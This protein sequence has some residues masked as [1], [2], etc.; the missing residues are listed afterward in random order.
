MGGG[1]SGASGT[2]YQQSQVQI[3][4]EVM[5]RYNAVNSRAEAAAATPW[6]PYGGQFVAPVNPTQQGGINTITGAAGIDTPY[7]QQATNVLNQSLGPTGQLYGTAAQQVGQGYGAGT[8]YTQQGINTAGGATSAAMPFNGLAAGQLNSAYGNTQPLNNAAIGL[9]AGATGQVNPG[10]LNIGQYMSPYNEGVVQST[11][12][13]LRQDQAMGRADLRDQ[14]IMGGSFGGDRSGVADANLQRQQNL[15]YGQTAAQLYNANYGQALGAAQ[16]QQGVGLSAAQANRAALASGAQ[17]IAGIGQQQFGQGAAAAQGNLGIGQQ[18]YGQGQGLAATQMQGGNQLFQQGTG[19]AGAN[20]GIAQ[21]IY[22]TAAGTANSYGQLGTQQL[23]NQLTQGQAQVGAGTVQQQTQQA[24]DTAKYQQFMQEKGYPFQ[25]AQFLANI[26]MG[27]GAQSGSTTNTVTGSPQP[28][29]SDERLKENVHVIGKTNDGQPIIR[30]NY[31]GDPSTQIGLSA[32]ETEKHHPDAVGLSSGFKTVDYDAAT[33]N[34]I[35]KAGGGGLSTDMAGILAQQ[36]AMYPG[37]HDPRGVASGVGPHGIAIAPLKAQAPER[38]KVDMSRAQQQQQQ[39]SGAKQTVDSALGMYGTGK[40]LASAYNEGKETFVGKAGTKAA[41]GTMTNGTQ[42]WLGTGGQLRPGEGSAAGLFTSKGAGLDSGT[43]KTEANPPPVEPPPVEPPPVEPPVVVGDAGS[44]GATATADAGMGAGMGADMFGSGLSFFAN[45]GGR[46]ERAAGGGA[47]P[48]SAADGYI[49]DELLKP[50]APDK[51]DEA[52]KIA[53]GQPGGQQ[54]GKKDGTGKAI[55]SLVGGIA[56]SYFGPIGSMAGST[57]GGML[58]GMVARGGRVGLATGGFETNDD[59]GDGADLAR[60]REERTRGQPVPSLGRMPTARVPSAGSGQTALAAGAHD[61]PADDIYSTG[62]GI[63]PEAVRNGPPPNTREEVLGPQPVPVIVR[64][65]SNPEAAAIASR[66]QTGLGIRPEAVR[67]GP[68]VVSEPPATG[69]GIRPEAVRE[70]PPAPRRTVQD[71]VAA[72]Q[73]PPPAS[74]PDLQPGGTGLAAGEIGDDN[75]LRRPTQ[76]AAA[77][78]KSGY[79]PPDPPP[80]AQNPPADTDAAIYDRVM[81]DGAGPPLA[82][83]AAVPAA[84]PAAGT[85]V[86]SGAPAGSGNPGGQPGPDERAPGFDGA[87]ARTFR[88]EG[89]YN[90]R[91]ANGVPVNFGINQAYHPGVDVSKLTKDQAR[92]IYKRQYWDAIEADKLDPRLQH[93]AFDTAVI[94]GPAKAKE[95]LAASGGDPAKFMQLREQFEEGLV[96]S[97]PAKYGKYQQSWAN[98]RADLRGGNGQALAFRPEGQV[99]DTGPPAGP[100]AEKKEPDFIERAGNWIDKYQRP[101][102]TGL[103]FIG[104]MLGSKSH[105]LTGA[106]GD[107][108]AAA[109]PMYLAT[110]YKETEQ[111]QGQERIDIGARA[112]YMSVLA[113]Q[114]QMQN[115]YIRAYKVRSPELD[116]QMAQ[117]MALINGKGGIAAA[118]APERGG[119]SAGGTTP[120]RTDLAPGAPAPAATPATGVGSTPE[121]GG[122]PQ[123]TAKFLSQLDPNANPDDLQARADRQR[124]LGDGPGA[125]DLERE[126]RRVRQE[127]LDTGVGKG[128]GGVPVKL[129]G[130]DTYKAQQSNREINQKWLQGAEAKTQAR[131]S[132]LENLEKIKDI[133]ENYETGTGASWKAQAAGYLSAAGLP[134]LR[135]DTTDQEAFAKFLKDSYTQVLSQGSGG[136]GDTDNLRGMI[137]RSFANPN[138]PPE[139]NKAI[140]SQVE[141]QLRYE[142]AYSKY[143]AE[144]IKDSQLVDQKIVGDEWRAKDKEKNNPGYHQ[145]EAYRNT[146]VLGATPDNPAELKNDHVYML[147]PEK[148]A[149]ITGADLREVKAAFADKNKRAIRYRVTRD[150]TGKINLKAEI[151]KKN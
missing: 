39:P 149:Q 48:F 23:Q 79:Y 103:A 145:A 126:S 147:T 1:K 128:P 13:N 122:P 53:G 55:G 136:G 74:I 87:V 114:Q 96:K 70:G 52:G 109:A 54:A 135:T 72:G 83:P 17:N 75:L 124:A 34:S 85:G 12:A 104:N 77:R 137:E 45:R 95:L 35:A 43:I 78:P 16:Q 143:M 59:G 71:W 89:G 31:T 19:A 150:D 58:G 129:E 118:P 125:D 57:A 47:L 113:R 41:D 99:P 60:E 93:M 69:L 119:P 44:L 144:R 27:T 63:V 106:I 68:P 5:A 139:A 61:E 88:F 22:G 94:S 36:R 84:T 37:A 97:D 49:P 138:L 7:F 107:G 100:P 101:I 8:G 115:D 18:V 112:Q 32:Q 29:F 33:R 76:A 140:L 30:Y 46:M 127:I 15:A 38:A 6:Q 110:G 25:V 56:G 11:L 141:G 82:A 26:A 120:A 28:F 92:D 146:A 4:P 50:V 108:L 10:D 67:E 42:G 21:G 24:E 121:T 91:D 81:R 51:P 130:W 20:A 64:R 86:A 9:A 40:G 133:V 151:R 102:M 65:P 90:P 148:F 62:Q 131:V 2:T 66:Q 80:V 142:D 134:V 98:R 14:Q 123:I 116:A 73:R 111:K 105:Q 117:T 3:P 132:S